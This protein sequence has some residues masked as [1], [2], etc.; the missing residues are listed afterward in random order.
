M[1]PVER[2]L[3]L[4][5]T[6]SRVPTT[7]NVKGSSMPAMIR[8]IA[9]TERLVAFML[10]RFAEN[11]LCKYPAKGSVRK[12][13]IA[14]VRSAGSSGRSILT[15]SSTKMMKNARDLNPT[16]VAKKLGVVITANL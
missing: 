1:V 7:T 15:V 14:P 2:I 8:N 5:A 9:I 10:L 4:A 6:R 11:F 16:T 3:I 13:R 12:A